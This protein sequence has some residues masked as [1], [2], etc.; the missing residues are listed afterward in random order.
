MIWGAL[1]V[2]ALG[3]GALVAAMR[4]AGALLRECENW[5]PPR[6]LDDEAPWQP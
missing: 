1:I 3:I 2:I 5:E 4:H 6:D